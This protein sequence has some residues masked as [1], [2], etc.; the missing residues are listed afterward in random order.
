MRAREGA[1]VGWPCM[2]PLILPHPFRGDD[3]RPPRLHCAEEAAPAV[4]LIYFA[5][6]GPFR[7]QGGDDYKRDRQGGDSFG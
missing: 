4:S 1:L 6:L 3:P 2:R 7:D 5:R